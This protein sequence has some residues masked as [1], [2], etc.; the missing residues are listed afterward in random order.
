MSTIF[1]CNCMVGKSSTPRPDWPVTAEGARTAL[2]RVGIARALVCNHAS[3]QYDPVEGAGYLLDEIAEDEA[4]FAGCP[5]A[6]PHW[7]G[8]VPEPRELLDRF[9]EFRWRAFRVYPRVHNFLFHPL[10]VGPLME[11]AQS[12]RFTVLINRDQF[13]WAELIDVLESFPRLKLV[14][15]NEGYR[16]VRTIFALFAKFPELRF[17]T[18]WLQPFGLYETVVERYG[19]RRLVFGTQ[20][21]RFEPGAS[22]APILRAGIPDEARET[23]LG[24]NLAEMLAEAV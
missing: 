11:E 22:L 20:F 24:G 17:E 1:D 12:R 3:V 16:T 7:A 2:Q 15:C 23:I 8:D 19:P 9:L 5:A 10:V 21:P 6:V 4:F 14:I 13:E 18:S